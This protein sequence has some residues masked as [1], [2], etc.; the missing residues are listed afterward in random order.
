[1]GNGFSK[2]IWKLQTVGV[3]VSVLGLTRTGVVPSLPVSY[4]WLSPM[5]SWCDHVE[6]M[7]LLI[8]ILLFACALPGPIG[9]AEE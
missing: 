9:E 5:V 6:R 8:R 2:E 3:N 7:I 1:M 4:K